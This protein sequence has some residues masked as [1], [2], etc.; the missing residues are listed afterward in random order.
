MAH[1]YPEDASDRS[2]AA[3]RR[4][5][6]WDKRTT[7]SRAT[8]GDEGDRSR[9]YGGKTRVSRQGILNV[10]LNE[11]K[12]APDF[13]YAPNPTYEWDARPAGGGVQMNK[14]TTP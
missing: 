8:T 2:T 11:L 14:N 1:G 7:A 5:C 10:T 12:S 13:Q 6:H 4:S 3:T 9:G